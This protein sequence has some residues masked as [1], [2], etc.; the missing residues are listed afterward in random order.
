M[1]ESQFYP[2]CNLRLQA[3]IEERRLQYCVILTCLNCNSRYSKEKAKRFI[4]DLGLEQI[5]LNKAYDLLNQYT[6]SDETSYN[7]IKK[8]RPK[9]GQ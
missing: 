9:I 6:P 8:I 5:D 2:K 3:T 7:Q 4:R 1:S